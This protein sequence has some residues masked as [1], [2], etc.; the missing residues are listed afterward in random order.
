MAGCGGPLRDECRS[1]LRAY[2]EAPAVRRRAD[3]RREVITQGA[4]YS[5]MGAAVGRLGDAG[6]LTFAKDA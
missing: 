2:S 3:R 4:K 1:C 6:Q 5:G